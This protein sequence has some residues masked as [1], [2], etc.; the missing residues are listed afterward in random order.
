[1]VISFIIAPELFYGKLQFDNKKETE[2]RLFFVFYRIGFFHRIGK[3]VFQAAFPVEI[4]CICFRTP[5][6]PRAYICFS[7]CELSGILL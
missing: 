3:N 2:I 5:R 1:M 7:N 6:F 4:D